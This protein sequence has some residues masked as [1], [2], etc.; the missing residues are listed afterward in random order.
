MSHPHCQSCGYDLRGLVEQS[1]PVTCPECGKVTLFPQ[2]QN[3]GGSSVIWL[4]PLITAA[5]CL[6]AL[7]VCV[8][9]PWW[10][11][12]DGDVVVAGYVLGAPAAG[13]LTGI[14]AAIAMARLRRQS[15]DTKETRMGKGCLIA[16]FGLVIAILTL[17]LGLVVVNATDDQGKPNN[18]GMIGAGTMP[19]PKSR[20]S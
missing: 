4:A 14:V 8:N 16:A 19:R 2:K 18:G 13:F 11:Y 1:G 6:T 3:A 20:P 10:S 5:V 12:R 7:G 15:V 9:Q 17:V